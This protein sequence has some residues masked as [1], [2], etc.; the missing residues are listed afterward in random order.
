MRWD[1]SGIAAQRS[2]TACVV[3]I[4]QVPQPLFAIQYILARFNLSSPYKKKNFKNEWN[5]TSL[6]MCC[7]TVTKKKKKNI[8]S[9]YVPHFHMQ[10][11]E[12]HFNKYAKQSLLMPFRWYCSNSYADQEV[13]KSLPPSLLWVSDLNFRSMITSIRG[14]VCKFLLWKGSFKKGMYICHVPYWKLDAGRPEM[15][16][17]R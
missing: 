16:L 17:N 1:C 7:I 9:A 14:E 10:D 15:R 8:C 11:L 2:P 3:N 12:S 5:P 6:Y 13:Q 4:L